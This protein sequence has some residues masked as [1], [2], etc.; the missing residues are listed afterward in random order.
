M[1]AIVAPHVVG[2]FG[3]DCKV[4]T[5]ICM[6]QHSN[7]TGYDALNKA[8]RHIIELLCVSLCVLYVSPI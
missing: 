3:H 7:S 8:L 1:L 2:A 4:Y 5:V 6:V